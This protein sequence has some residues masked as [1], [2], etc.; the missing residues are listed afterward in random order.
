MLRRAERVDTLIYGVIVDLTAKPT[1]DCGDV[2]CV[3]I[4][5]KKL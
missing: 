1:F 4:Y 5:M 3:V 2:V